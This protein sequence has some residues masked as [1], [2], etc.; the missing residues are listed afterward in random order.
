MYIRHIFFTVSSAEKHLGSL[1]IYFMN[2][3][4]VNMGCRHLFQR[5]FSFP[6]D[7]YPEM[8]L[9]DHKA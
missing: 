7:I 1:Y 6:L 8:G 9:L 5:L 2:N 3:A 4:A